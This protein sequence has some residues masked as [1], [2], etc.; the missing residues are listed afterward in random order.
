M[1]FKKTVLLA[2]VFAVPHTE[3]SRLVPAPADLV[4]LIAVDQLRPDYLDRW[5]PQLTGGFARL[6]ERGVFFTE[7]IQDHALTETA[8]GHA[9]MLSG[10]VPAHTRIWSN[11]GG[12]EDPA[13]PLLDG[14]ALEADGVV[15]GASPR[16]F[17]G[18]TLVD[19]LRAQDPGVRALGVSRKDRA[20]ILPLGRSQSPSTQSVWFVDGRFTTSTYY[21]DSLPPWIKAWNARFDLAAVAGQRWTLAREQSAYNEPDDETWENGG[22]D[23]V[24][25]HEASAGARLASRIERLPWMDSITLDIALTGAHT[26]GLG[27]RTDGRQPDVLSVSLSTT[28]ALGHDYGPDS[29]EVHDHLLRLDRWI[30]SFL[31][32]LGTI[33]SPE[34]TI[35]VLTADHGVTPM[36]ERL[37]RDGRRAGRINMTPLARKLSAD[38]R[39]RWSTDFSVEFDNGI[40]TADVDAMIARGVNVDS[41]ARGIAASASHMTGVKKIY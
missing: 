30:G 13:S 1:R 24:F 11:S 38:L 20:A 29:R 39:A 14:L 2:S 25:P 23:R 16:R 10:R 35:I 32:S 6:R 9:T 17:H 40:L 4:V 5:R 26:L 33:V 21:T 34:R 18:T 22:K 15:R 36:P 19:W 27:K 3:G 7:A 41:I 12:V 28:D 8:P 37:V 31:D